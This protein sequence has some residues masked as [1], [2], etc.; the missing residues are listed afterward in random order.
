MPTRGQTLTR[1][2]LLIER[3]ENRQ[4][5]A[6]ASAYNQARR[7]IVS[8]LLERWTG[9]RTLRPE[10]AAELLRQLALLAQIDGRLALLERE[11]GAMLRDAV[12]AASELAVDQV[13]REIA[14]L[15]AELRPDIRQFAQIDTRMIERFVPAVVDEVQGA[16]AA[17]RLQLRRELQAGLIQGQPFPDLVR[18]LMAATPTGEAPAI[19]RNGQLSAER[20]TRRL[21]ITANNAA[22]EASLRQ[23]NAAGNVR[24]QKQ[25]VASIGPRTTRTCLRVH[26]QIRNVDEPFTLTAEPRFAREMMAPAFH[27]NCR[28]SVA[29]YHPLFERGGL[30]TANMQSSARAELK[31]RDDG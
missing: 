12:S 28:T 4:A 20:L 29:M 17:L 7:E 2:Q 13:R 10:E 19:W 16:T 21:V 5:R 9:A 11:V 18:R 15:P 23:I 26:G 1:N 14:L 27:W 31:R 6:V 22:K 24:V 30:N 3:E 25:A 8:F